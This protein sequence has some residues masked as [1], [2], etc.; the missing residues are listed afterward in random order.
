MTVVV[1]AFNPSTREA[2]AKDLCEF[3]ASLVYRVS[4]RTTRA[5]QRNPVLVGE[6]EGRDLHCRL[7]LSPR[8]MC[9]SQRMIWKD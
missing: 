1:H 7:G 5:T 2:A 9:L 6:E 8:S 3:K 4:F